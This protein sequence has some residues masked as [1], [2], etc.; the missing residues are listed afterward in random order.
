MANVEPA[1]SF[2]HLHVH[3]H[4]SLLDGANRIEELVQA[5]KDMGMPAIAVTD[6][7]NLFGAI[8]FYQAAHKAGVKPIL[9]IEAYVAPGDRRVKEAKGIAEASYHLLLLAMNNTGYQNL[10]KLASIGY[11]EGFYYRPRIDHDVLAAHADGLIAASSCLG[12]EIPDALLKHDTVRAAE[13]ADWYLSIFGP[14]RFF[15]E[16]QDHGLEEQRTIN[17]E[18]IEIARRK[19]AGLIVTNDVHYLTHD[20]VEAHDVLCCIS[21]RALQS[22]EKRFKF[23]SDQFFL[24]TPEQ[25]ANLF[26][27]QPEAVANT[28]AIAEKCNVNLDFKKRYTPVYRPPDKQTPE[29]FLSKLV[30]QGAAERYGEITD[31]MRERIEYELEVIE[32]KGFSSYFLI[33]WDFVRY[34]RAHG[35]PC[36]A[37]G[38]GCSSIVAYCLHLSQPDPLRYG[39]YFERFMDP[40]RDEMPDIDID[41]CQDGREAVIQYV[42]E[43]YG[44]V[45]QIITFGT[46]KARAAIRDVSRVLGVPLADADRVAK[47][48]PEELKMTLD[49]ALSQEPELS[50][51]YQQDERIRKVIDIGRRIEGLSRNAS[52]HAAGVVIADEP[53]VGLL[54]LYKQPD[55]DAIMTQFE[56]TTVEKVGLLKM[57][58]LGLRTLSV[59][60]RTCKLVEQN[61]GIT[62][63]LEHLD[64]ADQR[65]F[66][67][68]VAGHTKGVFQFES[69]GMRDVLTRMRP[70]RIEDLIAANAL[71][72]PGPMINIDAY[73]A[74]KHGESWQTP[75]RVMSEVLAETHGI[76]VYQEQVARLVNQ[77]GG[78]ERKR[79]FRLAK[80]ISKKKT[81][82][83]EAEREPFIAGALAKGLKKGEAQEIFNQILPF[84]EYAFNKAH[85]TGYALIAFQTAYLK[86]YY[87]HEF[88]AA[89]LTYEMGDTDK[90]VEYIEECKRLG[91]DVRPPDINESDADFTVVRPPGGKG[92]PFLRFGLAAIKGVG[93]KAVD[94]IV[95]ARREGGPFK[96]LFDFCDRVD[97]TTVNRGVIEAQIKAGAFDTTGAM[98]K[99][100][101]QVLD[102]ALRVGAQNQHD[103]QSGQMNM[104]GEFER[105]AGRPAT[106]MI[107]SEEWNDAE[108][109]AYEKAV[110]GFYVTKHPLAAHAEILRKFA[111]ADCADLTPE[112]DGMEVV[113]GGMIS[114]FRTN[115]TKT[116]R[117]AG[118]KLAVLTFE[119]TTGAIEAV[120]F[121]EEL[122]KFRR[123]IGPD[124][125]VFLRGR[126]DCRREEPSLRVSEVIPFADGPS[127]LADAVIIRVNAAGLEPDVLDRLRDICR[128]HGGDRPL[129]LHVQSQGDMTTVLR[130]G[131]DM[132]VRPDDAFVT[133]VH[134]LLGEGSAEVLGSRRPIQRPS[135]VSSETRLSPTQ[136]AT[137]DLEE[138]DSALSMT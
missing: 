45:A 34:A 89:L 44:H 97:L 106:P 64:L 104:F 125:I 93:R 16:L 63:D 71:Y 87:P 35:I 115:T 122:E 132:A 43:K 114:R 75:H 67:L 55:S 127:A 68:F 26:P 50:R 113:L 2:V 120:V 47:L 14:E 36:G 134:Q 123:F 69:G 42:R 78:I 37:R 83:I 81:A 80:A 82:M 133:A 23:P 72:R 118:S 54:P 8:E 61:H 119:D 90:V 138:E 66:G 102:D 88:M 121:A 39:L 3:T 130:C 101:M 77:L 49:K 19:G 58:F 70:N 20:D 98:R 32:S 74:R 33:C 73:I 24:K 11:C 109:L 56:G 4:F 25:M 95:A 15:I 18:L 52:V 94:C 27:N 57:D 110:L 137:T 136:V 29:E 124:K 117:N 100:L 92:E 62:V 86:T 99:A 105:D 41:I 59:L 46:L 13:L 111:T 48:V 128:A 103:R 65:V 17:P 10:L 1:P 12:A 60:A 31:E 112:A 40:D 30:Y 76:I 51:L 21:T 5:V 135:A 9:G 22:E 126:V 85:S 7:G 28:V 91:I 116:G 108:M 6:H 129:F 38:S 79:A 107:S 84:G 131:S 53:L 96:D